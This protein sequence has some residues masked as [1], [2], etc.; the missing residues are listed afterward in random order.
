M[1]RLV[2]STGGGAVVR[3]INWYVNQ[4]TLVKFLQLLDPVLWLSVE[5]C[6]FDCY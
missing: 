3:P 6:L 2:V 5:I 1:H 4:I